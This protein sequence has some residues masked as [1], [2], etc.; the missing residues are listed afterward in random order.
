MGREGN[1]KLTSWS[2]EEM[3]S[4]IGIPSK[5]VNNLKNGNYRTHLKQTVKR[6]AAVRLNLEMMSV[7]PDIHKHSGRGR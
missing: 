3:M 6:S 7:F 4:G 2:D 1:G 5:H